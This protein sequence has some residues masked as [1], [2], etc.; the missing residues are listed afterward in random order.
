VADDERS[1]VKI[2]FLCDLDD[3]PAEAVIR[4]IGCSKLRAVNLRG[5]GYVERDCREYIVHVPEG[6]HDA[7][8]YAREALKVTPED[9]ERILAADAAAAVNE[10]LEVLAGSRPT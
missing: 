3:Q 10:F 9:D 1:A 6:A 4:P 5:T 2:E 8:A 7:R